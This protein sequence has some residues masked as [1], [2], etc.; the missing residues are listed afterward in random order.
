M[1]LTG[2]KPTQRARIG[3]RSEDLHL[4]WTLSWSDRTRAAKYRAGVHKERG[5]RGEKR[6]E[7]ERP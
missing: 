6:R 4:S 1:V 2:Q 3:E 7:L 5:M